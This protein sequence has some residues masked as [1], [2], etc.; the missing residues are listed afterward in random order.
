[1]CIRLVFVALSAMLA[2]SSHPFSYANQTH[3]NQTAPAIPPAWQAAQF[4]NF[5]AAVYVAC[6]TIG[7]AG[8]CVANVP[9][10][11]MQLTC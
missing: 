11:Q 6:N 2:C 9:T 5:L 7:H 8:P 3:A 1:M 4:G 10:W